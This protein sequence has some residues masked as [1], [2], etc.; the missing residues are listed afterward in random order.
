MWYI[1]LVLQSHI[2]PEHISD[3]VHLVLKADQ[4][5]HESYFAHVEL[6]S[7][8]EPARERAIEYE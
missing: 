1:H 3:R 2:N 4:W 7:I 5:N 8:G 6:A